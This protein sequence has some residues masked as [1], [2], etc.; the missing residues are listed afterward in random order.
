[1]MSDL[2]E[3]SKA[4]NQLQ[5]NIAA[6]PYVGDLTKAAS[7]RKIQEDRLAAQYAP[8][9][10]ALEQQ[11]AEAKLQQTQLANL[12]SDSKI[13]LSG[14]TQEAMDKT[15]KT[16]EFAKMTR[17]EQALAMSN[18][19]ML[20]GNP[21]EAEKLSKT[22]ADIEFKEISV[23]SKQADAHFKELG[24]VSAMFQGLTP[25]EFKTRMATAPDE[26][27]GMI[28]KEIPGW[29]KQNNPA[30]QKEQLE[31]L[32]MSSREHLLSESIAQKNEASKRHAA[33][34]VEAAKIRAIQTEANRVS[35]LENKQDVAANKLY[36]TATK[37]IDSKYRRQLDTAL[38][39]K[40]ILQSELDLQ[41]LQSSSGLADKTYL[42]KVN[43][44]TI[45]I[46]EIEQKMLKEQIQAAKMLPPGKEKALILSTL[47]GVVVPEEKEAP[48]TD[49]KNKSVS[50]AVSDA[51]IAALKREIASTPAKETERLGILNNELEKMQSKRTAAPSTTSTVPSNKYTQDNPA[52]PTSKEEYDKLPGGSYYLKDGAIKQ[53]S[54]GKADEPA[55]TPA[56]AA[57]PVFVSKLKTPDQVAKETNADSSIPKETKASII[58][59]YKSGYPDALAEEK[60]KATASQQT[61][62]K[63]AAASTVQPART[64]EGYEDQLRSILEDPTLDN[65]KRNALIKELDTT[66]GITKPVTPKTNST[67]SIEGTIAKDTSKD[68]TGAKTADLIEPGNIDLTK[69]PVVTNKDGSISTVRSMSFEEDG[70]Q[71]LIPTVVGNKVVSD[72]A[73]IDHYHKTGEHLGMFS[74]VKAANAYAKKLHEEQDKMYSK[75]KTTPKSEKEKQIERLK[76]LTSDE[77]SSPKWKK[78]G[79]EE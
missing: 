41:R 40:D 5:Q 51:D 25:E 74:S 57:A 66:F 52:K 56:P 77:E 2:A 60:A 78:R 49:Q 21:E 28:D 72:K 58:N 44:A 45:R 75:R 22:A 48:S 39:N 15:S 76:N 42:D 9:Q 69:R 32:L 3:G 1:M 30:A 12:V 54:G 6:A 11:Q 35:G 64:Q 53:K 17:S 65:K 31:Y 67:R 47:T 8:Q 23:K 62:A 79:D 24:K 14:K 26:L 70:M 43:V 18:A 19:V 73:A 71:I 34:I 59:R 68:F 33:A 27:K 61:T 37:I 36:D 55:S 50:A 20:A 7:E 10:A 38:E 46:Q 29:S 4:V 13:K 16:P 63:P